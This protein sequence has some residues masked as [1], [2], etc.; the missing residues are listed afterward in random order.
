MK[1]FKGYLPVAMMCI[2]TLHTAL[3]TWAKSPG[4]SVPADSSSHVSIAQ[5]GSPEVPVTGEI[6]IAPHSEAESKY[7]PL[8]LR[9][10]NQFHHL[11]AD[12]LFGQYK[13]DQFD[14]NEGVRPVTE[15]ITA[16][17]KKAY[18]LY[19]T[20]KS[21]QRYAE[22]LDATALV[23]LPIGIVGKDGSNT[24]YAILID[25]LVI[26]PKDAYLVVYM[27]I[28]IPQSEQRLVFRGSNIRFTKEGGLSGDA[29]LTLL[30]DVAVDMFGQN[31]RLIIKGNDT[32]AEWDCS[33]FKNM[34]LSAEVLFSR[35]FLLPAK[36]NEAQESPSSATGQSGDNAGAE[37]VKGRFKVQA[38]SFKDIV[39]QID[40]DPFEVPSL[41]GFTFT[42]RNAVFDFSD[43]Q[44]AATVK[45]PAGYNS[46]YSGGNEKL[47]QGFYLEEVTVTLPPEFAK[48][49]DKTRTSFAG[50]KLI[51][52]NTGFSGMVEAKNLI[53]L[54][55]GDMS[56]WD[57]SLDSIAVNFLQGDLRAAGFSGSIVVPIAKEEKP[58]G[59]KATINP[60]EGSYLFNVSTL[61]DLEFEVW[62]AKVDLKKGSYLDIHV[63]KG[64]FK[65]KAVLTGSMDIDDGNQT[66]LFDIRFEEL[67]ITTE[68]PYLD[69]KAFSFGSE[70][71]EQKMKDYP[72]S[73]SRIGLVRKTDDIRALTFTVMVHL[74][75]DDGGTSFKGDGSFEIYAKREP[76]RQKWKF[77]GIRISELG[78][79]LT[80]SGYSIKGRIKIFEDDIIYGKG[81]NGTAEIKFD[82]KFLLTGTVIFGKVDNYRYFYADA[83]VGLPQGIPF[84]GF[85]SFY[86]FG[87]GIYHNME[88]V[89]YSQDETLSPGKSLSGIIYKPNKEVK[90]GLKAT[91]QIGL[92]GSKD[93]FNGDVTFEMS[94]NRGGGIRRIS[95][96]GNGYLFE[97]A[98]AFGE[99]GEMAKQVGEMVEHEAQYGYKESEDD[100][101]TSD[102]RPPNRKGAMI[103]GHVFQYYDF[104]NKVFHGEMEMYIDVFNVIKGIGP[105]GMAGWSVIHY[106]DEEWYIYIGTPDRRVGL[107]ILGFMKTDGYFML[108]D[109]IEGSPALPDRITSI[110]GNIDLTEM[111]D[112]SALSSGKGVAFGASF[113][114]DTGDMTFLMFYARFAMGAGFDFMLKKFGEDVRCKGSTKQIGINGW[115]AMGQTYAF[116]EG[117]IGIKF[118]LFGKR[119]KKEILS[120]AAAVVFQSKMPNPIWLKGIV[121]GRFSILGGLIKGRCK[122]EVEIGDKCQIVDGSVVETL[123]VISDISPAAYTREVDVFTTAQAV[124][125]LPV[126]KE[127]QLKDVDDIV[128]S[129]R[130][131]LEHFKVMDGQNELPANLTWNFEKDVLAS[132]NLDIFP[133]E[134]ELRAEVMISFEEKVNGA[135]KAVELNGK[136]VTEKKETTFTTGTAPDHIPASNVAYSYPQINQFNFYRDEYKKGYIKLK[137]GQPY[138]F[139]VSAEWKQTGRFVTSAGNTIATGFS[140]AGSDRQINFNIPGNLT[141]QTVYALELVNVPASAAGGIDRNISEVST[142]IEPENESV[143][144]EMTSRRAEGTITTLQEQLLFQSYFRTS[145][146]N[147]FDAKFNSVRD[148]ESWIFPDPSMVGVF[149]L[150]I[151][152]R[153]T[154]LFDK[155]EISGINGMPPLL[156][157]NA[158]LSGNSWYEREIYPLI[159]DGYPFLPGMK[160]QR[161]DLTLGIPPIRAT[162]IRQNFN[163]RILSAEDFFSSNATN[164]ATIGKLSYE[165]DHYMRLDYADIESFA[166]SWHASNFRITNDRVRYILTNTYPVIKR[167]DHKVELRYVLPGTNIVTTSRTITIR[168]R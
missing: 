145:T 75:G 9:S 138:L 35:N 86:G 161:R 111:R 73:F 61:E 143:D 14:E 30:N 98:A 121:G 60:A 139:D 80:G 4:H 33:G 133:P 42:V 17:I 85:F 120:I 103:S 15:D 11:N 154:D 62:K 2:L 70:K 126:E 67:L 25:S 68:A 166:A 66:S 124:F 44:N 150:G 19:E 41:K 39:A 6:V 136:K 46:P 20:V 18:E 24:D 92:T 65:P 135:W 16:E 160:I 137:K 155:A 48:R 127:F 58:F 107:S 59:Y 96:M 51:I 162:F 47:W 141:S 13:I 157:L 49:K 52:D 156:Q 114:V 32:W 21:G 63:D 142:R 78:I 84:L 12:V 3:V 83:F 159:Y 101:M 148:A 168:P 125:N 110:L 105:N 79:D 7:T 93:T 1:L 34:A 88:Q 99:L 113:T 94:F 74:T 112:V 167:I 109:D 165:L 131:K 43:F 50:Y 140:Y 26:T 146:F 69:A 71:L 134:K 158:N 5:P 57:F 82:P 29:K 28:P 147:T 119:K 97:N 55:D 118:K 10:F 153:G 152:L 53:L 128:K 95:L 77:D 144:L 91:L 87:G 122:F 22:F 40:M 151:T 90:F 36:D 72:V 89:G 76:V 108:G 37:R 27:C 81:Y 104:N 116:V 123:A 130:V 54:Q 164:G 64:K 149:D 117:K 8:N 132:E 106:S 100:R 129:F 56:G 38:S 102:L 23:D 163:D 31:S 45:F 115:F